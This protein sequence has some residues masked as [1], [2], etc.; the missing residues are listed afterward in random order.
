MLRGRVFK[1][2]ANVDTD[3]IIPARYL[4]VS[5]PEEL[6]EHCMEDWDA[7]FA[8]QV[9]AGDVLARLDDT[10]VLQALANAELQLQQATLQ[11]GAESTQTGVS[12]DDIA[13]EQ[14]RINR[15]MAQSDLDDLLNWQPDE[16]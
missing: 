10:D 3:A 12:Y 5:T 4:N 9:Q 1:Y 15:D 13:V 2:G 11:T 14:A 6:A 7:D 8:S 16:D